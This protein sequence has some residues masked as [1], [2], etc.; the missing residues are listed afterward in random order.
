[1]N[2]D[3]S[4]WHPYE[5]EA[6]QAVMKYRGDGFKPLDLGERVYK[7]AVEFNKI[8]DEKYGREERIR[9]MKSKGSKPSD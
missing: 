7:T 4:M 3:F 1:M 6:R 5:A 9:F 8:L 2:D